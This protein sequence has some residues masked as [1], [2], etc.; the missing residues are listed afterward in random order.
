MVSKGGV[1]KGRIIPVYLTDEGDVY[2]IYFHSMEEL[3]I[4]QSLIGGMM[5][6]KVGVDF[7]CQINKPEDKISIFDMSTRE[8]K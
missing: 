5:D 4:I 6:H 1:P 2:P 3:D 8:T 7:K